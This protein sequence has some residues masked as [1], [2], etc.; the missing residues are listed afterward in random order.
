[1][2][3]LFISTMSGVPWGGSE[4][5]WSQA[6][7][8]AIERGWEVAAVVPDRMARTAELELLRKRGL[9]VIP[10]K[11]VL[12]KTFLSRVLGRLSQALGVERDPNWLNHVKLFKPAVICFSH[13][14]TFDLFEDD[15]LVKFITK[16]RAPRLHIC[17]LNNEF[18]WPTPGT[19]EIALNIYKTA[20]T[21]CFVSETNR[22]A[23]Q[24]QLI[25][26]L[27]D[28]VIVRNPVN[29]TSFDT[30]DFPCAKDGVLRMACVA[31]L[32][33]KYKGFDLL[34]TALARDIWIDRCWELHLYG[35][36]K[37][38]EDI[39]KLIQFLDL[40]NRVFLHGHVNDISSVWAR[41]HIHT[42]PSRAEGIPLALVESML[43]GR[44]AIVTDVGGNSEWIEDGKSGF[45]AQG[46]TV[47]SISQA[48]ERMWSNRDRLREMGD[49]ARSFALGNI[50]N[51]PADTL[52]KYLEACVD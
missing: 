18:Y 37:D 44:A 42:L 24:R 40:E 10:R 28:S 26:S 17:Q 49:K 23:A 41:N 34:L 48:L 22:Q 8:V 31:R 5:L 50:D 9:K 46:C 51:R 13:G 20:K 21:V 27:P 15:E 3:V 43:M 19:R 4:V 52:L 30:P 32:D 11:I 35:E 36:G 16:E 2:K 25:A 45:V 7:S 29:V 38:K 1:V 12:F 39:Q 6:A 47:T 14:N 33:I